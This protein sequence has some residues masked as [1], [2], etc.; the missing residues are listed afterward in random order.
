MKLKQ[1]ETVKSSIEK[2]VG[3]ANVNKFQYSVCA[4]LDKSNRQY[5]NTQ[6]QTYDNIDIESAIEHHFDEYSV[7]GY[8]PDFREFYVYVIQNFDKNKGGVDDEHNDCLFQAIIR[9]YNYDNSIMPRELN[10]AY[11]LKKR[12]G[13]ERNDL[14]DINKLS[15]LENILNCS[16]EVSGDVAYISDEKKPK[17]INL[18]LKNGHYNFLSNGL[19]LKVNSVKIKSITDD[20][21]YSYK[22][23]DGEAIIFNGIETKILCMEDY[24]KLE[25][26]GILFV[27]AKKD[28][29]DV[30]R[31]NYL[32]KAKYLFEKYGE[33]I[34][35]YKSS[36]IAKLNY[37]NI[38][39]YLQ[40]TQAPDEISNHE[41]YVIDCAFR[42]GVR[43]HQK[44]EF[45]NIYD[46]DINTMYAHYLTNGLFS[47]PILKPEYQTV[48]NKDFKDWKCFQ[49]GYYYCKTLTSH[50]FLKVNPQYD[51]YTHFDLQ[52]FKLLGLDIELNEVSNNHLF[53]SSNTRIRGNLLKPYVDKLYQARSDVD[54]EYKGDIK[55]CLSTI[56]GSMCHKNRKKQ[57]ASVKSA[58]VLDIGDDF[59]DS[60]QPSDAGVLLET[61]S[62]H[63]I[64][65]NNYARVSF[66]TAYCRL[67][68]FQAISK[69]VENQVDIVMINT[70]GFATKTKI[71]SIPVGV[72]IG[73]FKVQH[74]STFTI[75]HLNSIEKV[76]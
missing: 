52:V 13:L 67:K 46:Y 74:Y 54:V 30:C 44:G 59:I 64:F 27:N 35:F 32:K 50:K 39:V 47:F 75:N 60:I 66:I 45:S 37:K 56:Y 14:V 38:L 16:F 33:M 15:V 19:S 65:K 1:N 69:Y 49:Y 61:I 21:I 57:F 22:I 2:A 72:K 70:D 12:L 7:R 18:N 25:N 40:G 11:K 3:K 63:K 51:W 48:T 28:E 71:D 8:K 53:Y 34:N 58:T 42:G 31:D 5:T 24:R 76:I 41:A 23:T 68:M 29:L 17:N 43:Y 62:S 26:S 4:V 9:A 20:N 55:M 6:F 10:K 73:E 36:C